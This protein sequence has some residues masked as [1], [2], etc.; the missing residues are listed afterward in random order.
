MDITG[1]LDLSGSRAL[2]VSLTADATLIDGLQA[3]NNSGSFTATYSYQTPS[4]SFALNASGSYDPANGVTGR[5]TSN[6]GVMVTLSLPPAGQLTGTV[7]ATDTS[8]NA[9]VT[10]A[11]ISGTT[12]SYTDGSTASLF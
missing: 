8:K 9:A 1:Q 12:I 11:S 4:G 10:T 2:S 6:T 3:G 7:T 5:L